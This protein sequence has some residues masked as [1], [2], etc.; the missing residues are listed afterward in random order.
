[1]IH[2]ASV[3][4]GSPKNWGPEIVLCSQSGQS[5]TSV[6]TGPTLSSAV[7]FM[8]LGEEVSSDVHITLHRFCNSD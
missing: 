4:T 2:A 1:M 3:K 8:F 7:L 6:L 5:M